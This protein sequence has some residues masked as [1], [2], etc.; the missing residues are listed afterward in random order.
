MTDGRE[1]FL[2]YDDRGIVLA[3][4]GAGRGG[5]A[6]QSCGSAGADEMGSGQPGPGF[7]DD[8]ARGPERRIGS[9]VRFPAPVMAVL[10]SLK[11]VSE[12]LHW[13]R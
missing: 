2:V 1:G 11:V 10:S 5:L 12:A 9:E 4:P 8:Q 3:V 13:V 7:L 6:V